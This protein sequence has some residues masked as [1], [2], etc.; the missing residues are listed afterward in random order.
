MTG[1]NSTLYCSAGGIFTNAAGTEHVG[2][3]IQLPQAS[4]PYLGI[5]LN[6]SPIA[7]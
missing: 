2:K 3:V 5:R 7:I 6:A 1:A 4:D